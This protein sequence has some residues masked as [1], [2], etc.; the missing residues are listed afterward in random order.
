MTVANTGGTPSALTSEVVSGDYS[1][2]ANTCG[3]TLASQT[4]CSI[5][6]VFAPTVAGTRQGTLT[7][8][9]DAGTQ[10]ASL[11]GVATS[12]ATDGLS[13][14]LLTFAAQVVNTPSTTQVVTLTNAGD[15]SL[16]GIAAT[17]ASGDFTVVNGC[18]NTLIGH[19]SCTLQVAFVPKSV[20]AGSGVL[21]VVDQFRS[22]QVVLHG[23]GLAPAGV[24]LTPVGGLAFGAVGLGSSGQYQT[25][26][27][28]NNGGVAL[29][30]GGVA[31]SGDFTVLA[32]SNTCG[33]TVAAGASCAVQ[34]GFVPT[35]GG[36]R[37]GIVTFT[38]SAA[39]S[40]QSLAL[41][42]TGIDFDL[43]ANGA[44]SMTRGER[45]Q[46]PRIRFC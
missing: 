10:T 29:A 30:F 31:V 14:L 42:G 7:V 44:T 32:G 19:A 17:I 34:I 40:P 5:S 38:D 33:S 13:P 12:P 39:N 26:T 36:V 43:A 2:S 27:L 21:T 35:V 11:R 20:G 37:N 9:D 45:Y 1:I 22:Q 8:I 46:R 4:A 6:I 18:G 41:T 28:T 25:V 16:T 23:V 3:S 24:S 15:V